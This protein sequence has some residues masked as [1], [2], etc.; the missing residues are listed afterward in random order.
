MVAMGIFLMESATIT[1]MI[2]S[3]DGLM[4]KTRNGHAV[5]EAEG[6]DE[7]AVIAVARRR[8]ASNFE[9]LDGDEEVLARRAQ[10]TPEQN[11]VG[12]STSSW[13]EG[14]LVGHRYARIT[15]QALAE[16]AAEEDK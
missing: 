5:F 11:R 12:E 14:F 9:K 3:I 4:N 1:S 13:V 15:A 10:R 6:L 7:N 8:M 16:L 2:D